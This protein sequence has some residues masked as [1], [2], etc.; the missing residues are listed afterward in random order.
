MSNRTL[1]KKLASVKPGTVFV[2]VDLA[3]DRNVAVVLTERAEQLSRFGFPNERDGYDYFYRRLD[4]IREQQ[5]AP[6]VLVGMEPTNYFWKLLAA[7]MEQHRP[8]YGYR[9][10][11]P[12]KVKKNLEGDQ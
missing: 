6:A 10:V 8:E 1:S 2:G 5:Q 11:N 12:Y 7:D 3:L 4:S 9:L